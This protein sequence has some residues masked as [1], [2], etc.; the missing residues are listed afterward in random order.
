VT[1]TGCLARGEAPDTFVLTRV[2]WDPPSTTGKS[3]SAH[4]QSPD[5]LPPAPA[6]E[7]LRLAGATTRLRLASYVGH[8][9]TATGMLAPRDPEVRPGIV[10]PEAGEKP[11]S[12]P[13]R[14]DDMPEAPLPRI[15]NVRSVTD[16]APQ[17]R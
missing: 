4:H 16:V 6:P 9:V 7:R 13:P 14:A 10:L 2:R 15:F 11:A 1:V 5:A 3:A 8:T 12:T 17:C